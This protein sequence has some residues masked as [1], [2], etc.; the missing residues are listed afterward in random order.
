MKSNIDLM[1]RYGSG[2]S[3]NPKMAAAPHVVL[4]FKANA[5]ANKKHINQ[6][7]SST[8]DLMFRPAGDEVWTSKMTVVSQFDFMF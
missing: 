3:R 1:F 4:I 5:V 7:M 2:E 6:N 8:I